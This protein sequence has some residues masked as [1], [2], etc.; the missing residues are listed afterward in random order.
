MQP[1]VGGRPHEK[2]FFILNIK[3]SALQ[4]IVNLLALGIVVFQ[5]MF[6]FSVVF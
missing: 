1:A 2:Q 6:S 3:T 4:F 5:D